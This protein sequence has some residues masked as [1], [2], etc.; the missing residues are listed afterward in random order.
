[1]I[2]EILITI[3]NLAAIVVAWGPLV[4]VV[5]RWERADRERMRFQIEHRLPHEPRSKTERAKRWAIGLAVFIASAPFAG[6]MFNASDAI[7]AVLR[8]VAPF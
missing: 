8:R 1:M 7:A 6:T 4:W 3:W 2:A 5:T